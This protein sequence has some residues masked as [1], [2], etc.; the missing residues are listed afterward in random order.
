[1]MRRITQEEFDNACVGNHTDVIRD[2]VIGEE[3]VFPKEMGHVRFINCVFEKPISDVSFY[4]VSFNNI[5]IKTGAI[6]RTTIFENCKFRL[7]S[8]KCCDFSAE[9]F[10][11]CYFGACDI[12]FC[13]LSYSQFIGGSICNTSFGFSDINHA[14]FNN[15]NASGV[16]FNHCEVGRCKV[17]ESNITLPQMIPSDGSFIAWK[18]ALCGVV[19]ESQSAV[20][21]KLR[22]PEDAKRCCV[23]HKCRAS[24]V[25]VLGFETLDGQK[26]SDDS[27][28]HSWYDDDFM[29]RIGT[30]EPFCFDD[31]L[32]AQCSDGI[33][34][35]LNRDD[36]VAYEFT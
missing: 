30:V 27:Y 35:F 1:M 18:K 7:V 23:A 24:K 8:F 20:I 16:T 31:D 32:T 25:E 28:V 15:I 29:Y 3:I 34:F 12:V 4:V 36:A 26:L 11:D 22:I 10:V 2:C 5:E 21:I 9:T 14:A 13:K 19:G 17:V 33:H 6:I